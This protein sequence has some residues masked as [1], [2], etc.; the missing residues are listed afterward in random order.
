MDEITLHNQLLKDFN[1]ENL[2]PEDQEEMLLEASKTIQKQ[3]ILDI[4]DVLGDEKFQALEASVNM[5][6]EFYKTTLKH[7]VPNYEEIFHKARTKVVTAFKKAPVD[8]V[9]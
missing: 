8:V 2:T 7:L 4:Y 9:Q 6:E 5:G 1:L 3:F